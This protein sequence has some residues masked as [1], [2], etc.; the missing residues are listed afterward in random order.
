MSSRSSADDLCFWPDL[1]DALE[2]YVASTS[3]LALPRFNYSAQ[4][5]IAVWPPL[6]PVQSLWKRCPVRSACCGVHKTCV[7]P[8]TAAQQRHI[9]EGAIAAVE[10]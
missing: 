5:T 10:L 9:M 6:P 3:V 7:Q 8:V 4:E 1:P 2:P